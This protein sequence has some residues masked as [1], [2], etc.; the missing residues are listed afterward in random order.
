M[1][2]IVEIALSMNIDRLR[3]LNETE[4]INLI[5]DLGDYIQSTEKNLANSHEELALT[6]DSL[7]QA[8]E[9]NYELVNEDEIANLRATNFALEQ[10]LEGV[11]RELSDTK[12]A[13]D[14]ATSV[15]WDLASQIPLEDE[16][17]MTENN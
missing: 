1:N 9:S 4:L 6:K 12:Q 5:K 11:K 2:D 17:D 13:L 8:L 10:T 7:N 15:N 16:D 14:K 3:T